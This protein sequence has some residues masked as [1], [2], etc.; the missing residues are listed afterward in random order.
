LQVD[1]L[2]GDVAQLRAC[3]SLVVGVFPPP[4]GLLLMWLGF[5]LK[6]CFWFEDFGG[7][8]LEDLSIFGGLDYDALG[9]G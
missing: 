2:V 4:C 1:F 5:G 7:L 6:V 3:R 8:R 9:F